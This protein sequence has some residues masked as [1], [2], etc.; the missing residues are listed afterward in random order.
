MHLLHVTDTHL[1]LERP[2]RG[3]PPGWRRADDHDAA[4]RAALQPALH[5]QVD[6]VVHSG[7]VFNRSRPPAR[8]VLRAL[9]LLQE[10]ARRVPVVVLPGNHDR[11]GLSRHMPVPGPGLHVFDRPT[12]FV[13]QGVALALVPFRRQAE[14]WADD[15]RRAVGPGADLLVA[16]QSFDGHRV[17]GLTFRVGHQRET[18]GEQHLPQGVRYVL[19]GHIH[20]RQVLS[21]GPATVVCPGSTERTSFSE[22]YETK[23]YALWTLEGQIRWSF[24][25]LPTRPMHMIAQPS[26]LDAIRPGHLV[27]IQQQV[28]PEAAVLRRGGLLVGRSTAPHARPPKAAAPQLPLFATG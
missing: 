10:V 24:V 20:P 22:R 25:D 28:V 2:V 26:D 21:L 19:C 11:H 16:H 4:L 8:D 14:A 18:V 13:H 9:A 1:G 7:D 23:G 6:L 3:G 5:E 15:A 17:P 27:R 12:R